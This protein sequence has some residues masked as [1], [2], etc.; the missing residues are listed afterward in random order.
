MWNRF[1]SRDQGSIDRL[2]G[3]TRLIARTSRT[4][5]AFIALLTP[6]NVLVTDRHLTPLRHRFGAPLKSK[7]SLSVQ[8]Q[9]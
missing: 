2:F 1:L 5:P 3:L 8:K 4:F 7:S 6:A 9:V